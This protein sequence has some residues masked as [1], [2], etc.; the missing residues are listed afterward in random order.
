MLEEH[1][2]GYYETEPNRWGISAGAI[3]IKDDSRY[4]DAMALMAAYQQERSARARAQREQARIDGS[5]ETLAQQIRKQP[6]RLVF[7]LFALAILVGLALWPILL[8]GEG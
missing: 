3:W 5:A 2:I 4:A 6:L 1:G 7:I 8:L